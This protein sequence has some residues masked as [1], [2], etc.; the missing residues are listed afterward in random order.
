MSH[1]MLLGRVPT[2]IF[3][4]SFHRKFVEKHFQGRGPQKSTTLGL[5]SKV[6]VRNFCQLGKSVFLS[7]RFFRKIEKMGGYF[8][9][10]HKNLLI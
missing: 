2:E 6:D 10:F 5:F 8:W 4:V 7:C 1:K 9:G 3:G